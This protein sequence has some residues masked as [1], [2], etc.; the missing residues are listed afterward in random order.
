MPNGPPTRLPLT[1]LAT[2]PPLGFLADYL[3]RDGPPGLNV[4]LWVAALIGTML[5]LA[6]FHRVALMGDGR[7]LLIPALFFAS[8]VAWRAS[9][10]LQAM[11]VTAVVLTLALAAFR[12]RDGRIRVGVVSEYA[13]ALIIAVW[14]AATAGA[15]LTWR[16][17]V[18]LDQLTRSLPAATAVGRG[19]LVAVPLLTVFG[20]LFFAADAV[21]ADLLTGIFNIDLDAIAIHVFWISAWSWLAASVLWQSLLEPAPETPSPGSLVAIRLGPIEVST[22]LGLLDLLFLGFVVVQVR[23]L[24]GGSG[25]VEDTAGL[26]YAEYARRGFFELLTVS[27]LVMPVILGI[28]WL[29]RDSSR[30]LKLAFRLLATGLI[31]L[32]LVVISSAMK[33]MDVYI[34]QFGLTELRLYSAAFMVWLAIAFAWLLLTVVLGSHRRFAFGAVLSAFLV[35][36]SLN[37]VNPDAFMADL[38]LARAEDGREFDVQHALSLSPDATPTLVAGVDALPP[39]TACELATGLK[40]RLPPSDSWR[41]WNYGRE[42]AREVI[43]ANYLTLETVCIFDR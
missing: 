24:F 21:F 16:H 12:L 40:R 37:V 17:L 30:A 7:W 33:R 29:M 28:H 8:A 15:V 2:A 32:V 13:W 5:S 38:N 6:R 27:A 35:L 39:A 20:A 41:N 26:T 3:F 43:K 4:F 36:A 18:R 19:L 9:P 10:T 1:I 42:E 11:N 23:Y 31:A 25:L 34:D 14:F 22:V